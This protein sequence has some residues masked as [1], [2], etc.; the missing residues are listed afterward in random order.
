MRYVSQFLHLVFVNL[1][2]GRGNVLFEVCDA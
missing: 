2:T 1:Q